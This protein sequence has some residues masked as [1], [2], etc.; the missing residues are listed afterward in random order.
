MKIANAAAEYGSCQTER[1]EL[2]AAQV[3][4]DRRVDEHVQRLRG[5][6]AEGRKSQPEDLPVVG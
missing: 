1:G 3:P 6:R 2:R 5:E 4:D